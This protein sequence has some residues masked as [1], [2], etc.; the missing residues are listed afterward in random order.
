[1]KKV[2]ILSA[3]L[4]LSACGC[5]NDAE[6]A[7]APEVVYHNTQ[8]RPQNCDYFDG[9]TC[10]RYVRRV[11]KA[12]TIRYRESAPVVANTSCGCNADPQYVATTASCGGCAPQVRETREPVEVVYKKTTY[13][14]VYTPQTT[15]SVS[16]ERAPYT[17]NQVV[18]S[19]AP[20]YVE[21]ASASVEE[22]I[23]LDV[24]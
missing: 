1:M 6:E 14:T 24:K 7:N 21:P 11:R 23:L 18:T 9:T 20:A 17:Q 12:P 19:A 22:E 15:A 5:M 8:V 4:A 16:Y 3:V 10:Y 13:K 2:L